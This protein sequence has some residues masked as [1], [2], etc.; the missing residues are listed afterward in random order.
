MHLRIPAH[1]ELYYALIYGTFKTDTELKGVLKS[2]IFK[3]KNK[4]QVTY[5]EFS[6][7]RNR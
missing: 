1:K 2:E 7:N 3:N 5:N 4:T 6:R